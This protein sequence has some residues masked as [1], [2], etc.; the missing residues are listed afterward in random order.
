MSKK[1]P[2]VF[3][4]NSFEISLIFVKFLV[5]THNFCYEIISAPLGAKFLI[6]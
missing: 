6:F 1:K 2:R 3:Q 4:K 5:V